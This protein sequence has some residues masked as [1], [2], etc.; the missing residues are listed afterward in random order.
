MGILDEDVAAVRAATDLVALA[1]EHLA[2]KRAGNRF[3][4]LCP[5]HSEKSPSFSIKPASAERATA[6]PATDA[7]APAKNCLRALRFIFIPISVLPG[8]TLHHRR[9]VIQNYQ[10]RR[11]EEPIAGRLPQSSSRAGRR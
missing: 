3:V 7:A 1:G 6:K 4:G 8:R 11:L 9:P 5:F 2:L 10:V